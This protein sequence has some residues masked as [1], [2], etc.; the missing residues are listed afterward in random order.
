MVYSEYVVFDKRLFSEENDN[1]G[2]HTV[3][4]SSN[5]EGADLYGDSPTRGDAKQKKQKR[6]SKFRT[7]NRAKT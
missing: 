6:R 3:G 2:E 7:M 1:D 5:A 4:T